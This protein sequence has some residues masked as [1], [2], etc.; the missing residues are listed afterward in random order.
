[1]AAIPEPSTLALFAMGLGLLIL[2]T[3]RQRRRLS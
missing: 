3:W 2:I 1:M